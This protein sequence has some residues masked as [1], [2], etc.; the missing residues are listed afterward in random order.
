MKTLA[1]YGIIISMNFNQLK[2]IV[3]IAKERNI[4]SAAKKLFVSQSSLSQTIKN[5]ENEYKTKFF[6]TDTSPIKLTFAGEIFVN[7]ATK[8]LK[9]EEEFKEEIK[10]ISNNNEVKI[11]VGMATHRCIYILPT[12]IKQ[13]K[14][15]YPHSLI[16]VKEYPTPT[17]EKMLENDELDLLVD[18]ENTDKYS[19]KSVLL[20]K[21]K[22]LLDVPDK[23]ISVGDELFAFKGVPFIM[24]SKE[25]ML[26]KTARDLCKKYKF[27]PNI[28]VECKNI[29]TAHSLVQ[30]GL[31]VT[32][33]PELFTKYNNGN[34]I[35]LRS[36]DIT[37]NIC[38]IYENRKSSFALDRFIQ[39]LKNSLDNL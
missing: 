8:I 14:K 7:W 33:V 38:A 12:V 1:K 20:K 22:I 25:Q 19:Y 32:F 16:V 36:L 27:E 5:L 9:S 18:I 28:S 26:G 31:G 15:E 35:E 3:T 21:E 4:T 34:F 29:E 24:L 17:L 2:Y 6:E 13:F 11:T 37:R 30:Q 10:R 23:Y 39:I